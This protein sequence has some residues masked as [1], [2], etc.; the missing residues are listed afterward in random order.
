[1]FGLVGPWGSGKSSIAALIAQ[2]LPSSWIV[3][4]FTPWAASGIAGL[5]LEFVAA[6]DSALGGSRAEEQVARAALRRYVKWAKPLLAAVPV[7]GDALAESATTAADDFAE[8]RPWSSEFD[9]MAKSLTDMGKRVLIVCDDIDRL[10]S[11]ELLEFLKVVRLLGRFPNVHY[12]VAYDGD[13]VEDLLVSQGIAGRAA[14]FMEKIVQHPF[15]LPAIDQATR[16]QHISSALWA[17]IEAHGTRLDDTGVNRLRDLADALTVGLAT[18]RQIARFEQHLRVL[19]EMVPGEVDLLDFA[20]IAF[21]RLNHHD[22]YLAL[23][24]WSPTLR[25]G[26]REAG[27]DDISRLS[28]SEWLT[29]VEETSRRADTSGV[30]ATLQFLFPGLTSSMRSPLHDKAFADVAYSERYFSL[31][32]ASNDVSDVLIERVVASLVLDRRDE[33]AENELTRLLRE[34][35]PSVARLAVRKARTQRQ[36]EKA[37]GH[38]VAQLVAYLTDRWRDAKPTAGSTD[39]P[40]QDLFEWLADEIVVAYASGEVDRGRILDEFGE[41]AALGLLLEVSAPLSAKRDE[42]IN[43]MLEDFAAFFSAQIA[44]P[45]AA[46]LEPLGYLRLK[47]SLIGRALGDDA[48]RGILDEKVDGNPESF[49]AAAIAMVR[50]RSWHNGTDVRPELEFDHQAWRT[51]VSEEVRQRMLPSLPTDLGGEDVD[52]EDVS[53]ENQ[54]RVGIES[55]RLSG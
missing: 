32:V 2:N 20:A 8:R 47:L 5:Q 45:G 22:V 19:A 55:A 34:A 37:H 17:T 46:A 11:S 52:M 16:F 3:Q 10:D 18:P 6:L 41:E 48:M 31:G 25:R 40:A 50:I 39:S 36:R 43:R 29:R 4:P 38:S 21:L 54:R 42:T 33:T 27:K 35:H 7:V 9:E 49:E 24:G 12:L 15:E 1:M 13:T 14:S 30:W 51:S 28:E 53:P 44:A 23:P 26:L